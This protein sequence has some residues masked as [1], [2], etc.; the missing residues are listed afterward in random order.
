MFNNKN[1][2]QNTFLE[3]VALEIHNAIALSAPHIFKALKM[4]L[5]WIWDKFKEKRGVY[6][7]PPLNLKL[8]NSR[9]VTNKPNAVGRSLNRGENL[10]Y[11]SFD[12]TTH[13]GI[14]GTTGT[15]KSVLM[16]NLI[17]RALSQGGPAIYF[18]PKPTLK[19]IRSFQDITAHFE[20][21]T[22]VLA[23]FYNGSIKLNPLIKGSINE[24]LNKIM[25]ALEWSEVFY[26]NECQE[27]LLDC[28]KQ[29]TQ[30]QATP[31]FELIIEKLELHPNKKSISSLI[32]Q[33]KMVSRSEFGEL[34]N[35]DATSI[36]LDQIRD[37]GA[38]LYIGISSI[39]IGSAGNILNKLIFGD[40]LRHTNDFLSGRLKN[41]E[42][43]IS[44]FFDELSSTVHEGF[45]DLLNKCR[46][47]KIEIF[48]ATQCPSD[49]D[50]ISSDLKNQVIENTNNLFVFNQVIPEHTDLFSSIAGT[51]TITKE[52][53]V[54]EDGF[55]SGRSSQRDVET[56]IAHPNL[57]RNLRIGQCLF[58]QR[59]PSKRIDVIN[60]KMIDYRPLEK[61]LTKNP[62]DS[63]F[64]GPWS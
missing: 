49:I 40:I 18:D 11:K 19:S 42:T 3:D 15:G 64:Q 12:S 31:T 7:N 59:K 60:V 43:R 32:S 26:K 6:K 16:Q 51:S 62:V 52:T 54:A 17:F 35:N 22:Y 57:I 33:L 53:F 10:N 29:I 27:A 48:Y 5:Y 37:E 38:C 50:R 14:F 63:A 21:K 28:L 23:S 34:I 44:I 9:K 45:I 24:N 25:D 46:E 55:R 36:T 2:K 61:R 30:T 8:I 47:A 41:S 13:T 20:K 39:G 56:L 4:V 1:K 58:I